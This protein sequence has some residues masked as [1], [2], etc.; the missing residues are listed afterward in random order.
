[1]RGRASCHPA[2][3]RAIVDQNNVS[4][5]AC[6]EIGGRYSGDA[7]TDDADICRQIFRYWFCIKLL[8]GAFPEREIRSGAFSGLLHINFNSRVRYHIS[9]AKDFYGAHRGEAS[10][11]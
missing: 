6:Q 9:L 5:L 10:A 3:D 7:R 2:T 8:R 1:M 4:T 11:E